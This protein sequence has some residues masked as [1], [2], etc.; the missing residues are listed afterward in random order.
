MANAYVPLKQTKLYNAFSM[1][2][3]FSVKP[4]FPPSLQ[5]LLN[6]WKIRSKIRPVVAVGDKNQT[7][8]LFVKVK[9]MKTVLFF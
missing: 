1:Y 5:K 8:P 3:S 7:P 2:N 9:K 6:V 4:L